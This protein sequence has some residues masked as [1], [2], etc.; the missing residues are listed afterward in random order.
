VVVELG[1]GV[2]R[3]LEHDS[4]YR[5]RRTMDA[6][7]TIS[8]GE[9]SEMRLITTTAPVSE[10]PECHCTAAKI[11]ASAP[12]VI[13]HEFGCTIAGRTMI[14]SHSATQTPSPTAATPVAV[15]PML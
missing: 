15:P 7:L 1:D 13:T 9:R 12:P 10:C 5:V 8:R 11:F 4:F 14:P 2:H 6:V 3:I